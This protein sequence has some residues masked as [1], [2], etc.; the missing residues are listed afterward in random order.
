VS[1]KKDH[2]KDEIRD[3]ILPVEG[4]PG[5][6]ATRLDPNSK[7]DIRRAFGFKYL[8]IQIFTVTGLQW[9]SLDYSKRSCP[10]GTPFSAQENSVLHFLAI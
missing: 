10:V 3:Q 4:V 5:G 7:I 8:V 6:R 2:G 9:F 1:A